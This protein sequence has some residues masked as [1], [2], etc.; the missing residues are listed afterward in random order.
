MAILEIKKK[1]ASP[2]VSK[3]ATS[4]CLESVFRLWCKKEHSNKVYGFNEF[5]RLKTEEFGVW[6]W[7]ENV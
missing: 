4:F 1:K 3:I 2:T 6:E 5:R 7:G